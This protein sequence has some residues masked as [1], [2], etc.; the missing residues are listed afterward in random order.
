[1]TD[2]MRFSFS[3]PRLGALN[4]SI[5]TTPH[6]LPAGQRLGPIAVTARGWH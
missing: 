4:T 1:M 2:W 5:F 6:R 3:P